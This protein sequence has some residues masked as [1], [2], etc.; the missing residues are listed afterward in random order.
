MEANEITPNQRDE[1]AVMT[2]DNPTSNI[3][4]L[5]PEAQVQLLPLYV[6]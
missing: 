4:F 1:M 2:N 6:N 3:R 5:K